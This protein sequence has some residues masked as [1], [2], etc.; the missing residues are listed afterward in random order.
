MD[1]MEEKNEE[2][3][4]ELMQEGE[5]MSILNSIDRNIEMQ[6]KE[7]EIKNKLEILIDV[8]LREMEIR[9]SIYL[10][11]FLNVEKNIY[12]KRQIKQKSNL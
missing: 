3:K 7:Q 4:E 10:T 12:D 8:K 11:K 1:S 2:L 6:A 9:A 5:K